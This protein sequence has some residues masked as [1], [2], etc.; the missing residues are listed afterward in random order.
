M[1]VSSRSQRTHRRLQAPAD[2]ALGVFTSVIVIICVGSL[3]VTVQ[4]KVLLIPV[5]HTKLSLT[6]FLQLL[7]GRV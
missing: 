1:H 6:A 5:L 4:A 7:G 3:V 2:Q